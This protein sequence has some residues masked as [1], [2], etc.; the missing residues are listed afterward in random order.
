MITVSVII[1][2]YNEEKTILTTLERVRAQN[3]EDCCFEIIVINDGSTDGTV[4]A[5]RANPELYD[6]LIEQ[7]SNRGKGSAVL[8]GLSQ[9]RG[10]YVLFQ[11][12]D[13]E[14]N[15]VEYHKLLFPICNFEADVVM[16]SRFMAPRYSRVHYFWNMLGNK[17]ITLIFNALYNTTFTDVY[18]CYLLY[19]R[20]LVDPRDLKTL[21]WQQHAEILSIVVTGAEVIYEVPISYHGRSHE[22]GKK[23]RAHHA[24]GVIWTIIKKRLLW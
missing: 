23:I 1:P 15:P 18:S 11:D 2:A 13:L 12:A 9:A 24:I 6:R 14:Y 10:D 5:L 21:G 8:A 7:P 3:V 22:E 17:F 19:R 4:D 16:G 20:K